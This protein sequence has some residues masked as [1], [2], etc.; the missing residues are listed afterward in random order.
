MIQNSG[1]EYQR[2]QCV[3]L[4]QFGMSYRSIG[5]ILGISRSSVHRALERFHDTGGFQDRHRSGRPRKVNEEKLSILRHLAEDSSVRISIHEM[6]I[7]LNESLEKPICRRTVINYMQQCNIRYKDK[8]TRPFLTKEDQ[9]ARLQWCLQYSAWTAN[10][11]ENVLFSHITTFYVIKS[12][13]YAK[14]WHATEYTKRKGSTKMV[15]TDKSDHVNF[16]CVISSKGAGCCRMYQGEINDSVYCDILDNYL[17]PT[18][19]LLSIKDKFIYQY[20]NTDFS[21]LERIQEKLEELHAQI[22]KWPAQGSDIN[23]VEQVLSIIYD[24]LTS[25]RISSLSDVI[26]LL[27]IEW[28]NVTPELCEELVLSMPQQIQNCIATHGNWI[29]CC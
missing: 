15:N 2:N 1:C 12:K 18:L 11:W 29:S 17:V 16:W 22:L 4:R 10:D 13:V 24:K 23:P 25:H 6:M 8:I 28:S 5:T 9:K 27:S 7:R 26:D 19:D 3:I 14:V 21:D 20:H